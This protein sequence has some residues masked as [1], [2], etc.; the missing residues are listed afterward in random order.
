MNLKKNNFLKN[1]FLGK[2]ET[3]LENEPISLQM[4]DE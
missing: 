1:D 4:K 3:Q 2:V